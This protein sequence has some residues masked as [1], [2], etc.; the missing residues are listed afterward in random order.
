MKLQGCKQSMQRKSQNHQNN[1]KRIKSPTRPKKIKR[2]GS[3]RKDPKK[4]EAQIPLAGFSLCWTQ[5]KEEEV[6]DGLLKP[7]LYRVLWAT[8]YHE[9]LV[10]AGW[11]LANDILTFFSPQLIK[12]ILNYIQAVDEDGNYLEAGFQSLVFLDL[13]SVLRLGFWLA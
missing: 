13:W 3:V 11:K 7:S 9:I 12:A 5:Y 2:N 6:D 1:Q 8:F 10:T 4:V